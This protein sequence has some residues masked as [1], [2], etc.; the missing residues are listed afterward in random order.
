MVSILLPLVSPVLA[1]YL[2]HRRTPQ[3]RT[4]THGNKCVTKTRAAIACPP[5]LS[6]ERDAADRTYY[7]ELPSERFS[8]PLAPHLRF[9]LGLK[10]R[11]AGFRLSFL[12]FALRRQSPGRG[13][14]ALSGGFVTRG[15]SRCGRARHSGL[16]P[17][18]P[19]RMPELE[20]PSRVCRGR[21]QAARHRLRR[22]SASGDRAGGRESGS[23]R[24]TGRPTP[25]R[26]GRSMRLC[27]RGAQLPDLLETVRPAPLVLV[28]GLVLGEPRM[29]EREARPAGRF[30]FELDGQRL[31]VAKSC[32]TM[33]LSLRE[34]APSFNLWVE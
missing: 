31:G 26:D 10:G 17:Q 29:G 14:L 12:S 16:G 9:L 2:G 28:A 22:C 20:R 27:S 15:R 33:W 18:F 19:D 11:T 32:S 25:N 6:A 24:E 13:G 21:R 7:S 4:P 3:H 5:S 1:P 23:R 34:F 30:R 8:P